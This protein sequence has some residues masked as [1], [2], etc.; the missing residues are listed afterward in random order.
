MQ[1]LSAAC[2]F[3]L[4]KPITKVRDTTGG[5]AFSSAGVPIPFTSADIDT[6]GMWNASYPTQLTVQTPGWYKLRYMV[7]Q[8]GSSDATN[9]AAFSTTGPNNPAGSG[10]NSAKYWGSYSDSQPGYMCGHGLWPFYLYAGDFIQVLG[11]EISGAGAVSYVSGT[12]LGSFL[13]LEFVSC[14]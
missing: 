2:T 11:I 3:L 4:T 9:A 13:S 10:S 14:T 5:T 1:N 6:D 7:A 12:D 8:S